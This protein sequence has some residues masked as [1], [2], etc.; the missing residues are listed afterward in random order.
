MNGFSSTNV[1]EIWLM[2]A[3]TEERMRKY[4]EALSAVAIALAS[5]CSKLV[6][7]KGKVYGNIYGRWSSLAFGVN[8][9]R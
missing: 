1:E 8:D 2:T 5:N 4:W 9:N 7:H 3:I 6:R